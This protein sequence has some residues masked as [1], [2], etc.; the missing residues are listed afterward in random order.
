MKNKINQWACY[1]RIWSN[2]TS[3][4]IIYYISY[5]ILHIMSYHAM[6]C[7][8]MSCHVISWFHHSTAAVITM[9]SWWTRWRLKSPA[10]RVFTQPFIQSQIKENIKA[11]RHWPL[12]GGIHRS[13]VNSPHKGPVTRKMSPFDDVIMSSG[14][15]IKVVR[16]VS[17]LSHWGRNKMGILQTITNVF[18]WTKMGHF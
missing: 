16:F 9:T 12:W 2:P 5:H 13:P 1:N 6:P 4:H 17:P 14:Q 15:I 8:A 3:Y 11:P 10:S 18:S 7:H